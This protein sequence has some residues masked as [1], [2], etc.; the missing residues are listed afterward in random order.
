ML[1]ALN[2]PGEQPLPKVQTRE[3]RPRSVLGTMLPLT[4]ASEALGC[5]SVLKENKF[6]E[7]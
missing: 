6:S 1:M 2:P 7:P 4:G 5:I 3:M